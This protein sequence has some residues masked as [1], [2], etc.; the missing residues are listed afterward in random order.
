MTLTQ[1]T[2]SEVERCQSQVGK[3]ILQLPRSSASVSVC[4]DAGLKPIWAVI[5]EKVLL[6]ASSTLKKATDYWPRMALTFNLA[7]G[8]KSPYTRYL[9]RWKAASN[10]N[11]VSPKNIKK[12][13]KNAAIG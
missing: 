9:L 10:C 1:A 7:S 3:F 4:I 8:Y 12:S 6:Y 11:L 13:V 2:I 5:A